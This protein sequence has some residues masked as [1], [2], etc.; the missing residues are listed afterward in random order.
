MMEGVQ[1]LKWT[2]LFT[3]TTLREFLSFYRLLLR[4]IISNAFNYGNLIDSLANACLERKPKLP[5]QVYYRRRRN[6]YYFFLYA[7]RNY[8]QSTSSTATTKWKVRIWVMKCRM[9]CTLLIINLSP[10]LEQ[11]SV[12]CSTQDINQL[13]TF[14]RIVN[15]GGERFRDQPFVSDAWLQRPKG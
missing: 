5:F 6:N 13:N 15:R 9:W 14:A 2:T 12:N 8:F 11:A 4:K 1:L 3:V 10:Y 7:T